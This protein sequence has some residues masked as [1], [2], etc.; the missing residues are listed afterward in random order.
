MNPLFLFLVVVND[1]NTHKVCVF[2]VSFYSQVHKFCQEENTSILQG[3]K[4]LAWWTSL[5]ELLLEFLP[6]SS[7]PNRRLIKGLQR[8]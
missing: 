7:S 8:L 5:E 2:L 4:K 3:V 1:Q 6:S